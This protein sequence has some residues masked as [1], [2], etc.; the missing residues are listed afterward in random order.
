MR[1]SSW[2]NNATAANGNM[3]IR[4]CHDKLKYVLEFFHTGVKVIAFYFDFFI[5]DT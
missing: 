5:F 4:V 3:Q 1:I 2:N